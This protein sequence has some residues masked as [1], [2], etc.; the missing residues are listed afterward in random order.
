M[1]YEVITEHHSRVNKAELDYI[2]QD[3]DSEVQKEAHVVKKKFGIMK[4]FS[5]KQTWVV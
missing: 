5:Y 1:L 2:S 4:A 3:H